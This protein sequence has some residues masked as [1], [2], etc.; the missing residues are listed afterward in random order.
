MDTF[1]VELSICNLNLGYMLPWDGG[2]LATLVFL[3]S[4]PY[5]RG[6]SSDGKQG[7]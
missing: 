5:V 3:K 7:R 1:H 4:V 2:I 6:R